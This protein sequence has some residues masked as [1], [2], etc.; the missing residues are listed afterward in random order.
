MPKVKQ[1]LEVM[2]A[3]EVNTRVEQLTD[4][5]AGIIVVLKP[6]GSLQICGDLTKLNEGVR[7]ERHKLPS[8][9]HISAQLSHATVFTKLNANAKFLE[10]KAL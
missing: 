2:K 4:W 1:E 6:K 8:V 9:E 10:D 5:Y 3:M 7:Q